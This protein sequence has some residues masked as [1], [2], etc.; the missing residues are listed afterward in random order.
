M[1]PH[2]S[3]PLGHAAERQTE[4]QERSAAKGCLPE[5]EVQPILDMLYLNHH[6]QLHAQ[7]PKKSCL[8]TTIATHRETSVERPLRLTDCCKTS[9]SFPACFPALRTLRASY[10]SLRILAC[11][12]L[13]GCSP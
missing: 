2:V 7:L 1:A 9:A 6:H 11:S 8:P 13:I 12:P 3:L 5:A 10:R 4:G